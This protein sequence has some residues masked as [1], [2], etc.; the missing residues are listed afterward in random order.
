M[1]G[2]VFTADFPSGRSVFH[3]GEGGAPT[4]TGRGG[5]QLTARMLSRHSATLGRTVCTSGG[6][7]VDFS[8]VREL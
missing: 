6:R 8:E 7:G 5:N 4:M 1:T 2:D 3:H